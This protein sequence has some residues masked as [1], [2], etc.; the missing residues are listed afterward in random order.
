V[1]DASVE[2]NTW[3][4]SGNHPAEQTREWVR[5][6][7]QD[8]LSHDPSNASAYELLGVLEL[9]QSES[10][11]HIIRSLDNFVHS[12]ELRPTSPY[13]WANIL[14]A[15]YLQGHTAGSFPHV[16]S[17]AARL[18]PFEPEVQRVVVDYGLALWDEAPSIRKTVTHMV[19]NGMRRSPKEMLQ[20][21]ERRGRLAVACRQLPAERR[22]LDSKWF[23]LCQGTEATL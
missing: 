18:G 10:E 1:Y 21:A 11:G 15:M 13:T 8:A 5:R 2:M 20:I 17:T 4:A 19:A 22:E 9:S 16:L 7:L 14:E 23:Q 3:A 6:D 12:A